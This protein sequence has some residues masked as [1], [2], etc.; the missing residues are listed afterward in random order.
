[1]GAVER[2][3]ME[4]DVE[5]IPKPTWKDLGPN[6]PVT[7]TLT[8]MVGDVEV[9]MSFETIRRVV[10]FD[11]RP[12]FIENTHGNLKRKD[13]NILP[14][15]LAIVARYSVIPRMADKMKASRESRERKMVPHCKLITTLMRQQ[16]ALH[17][18]TF[19]IKKQHKVFSLRNTELIARSNAYFSEQEINARFADNEQIR[20]YEDYYA[21]RP[22]KEHPRP[23]DWSTT[24]EVDISVA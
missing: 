3:Q 5:H 1:M 18:D 23:V 21:A 13:L 9:V 11:Y 19:Y 22:Y 17:E 20:H 15:L 8:G 12:L 7:M 4:T 10:A 6:P 2:R 16:G 24:R 14:K